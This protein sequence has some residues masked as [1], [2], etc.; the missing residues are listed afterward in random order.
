MYFNYI[1][2]LNSCLS[3]LMGIFKHKQ[4]YVDGE[5][6][7]ADEIFVCYHW[8]RL[9]FSHGLVAMNIWLLLVRQHTQRDPTHTHILVFS[10]TGLCKKSIFNFLKFQAV[11][12]VLFKLSLQS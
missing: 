1:V 8:V 2:Y 10:G 11:V 5:H 12:E 3:R 9:K 6:I 4:N 7:S